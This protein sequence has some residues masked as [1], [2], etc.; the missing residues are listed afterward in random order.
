MTDEKKQLEQ[1]GRIEDL[2]SADPEAGLDMIQNTLE[3]FL[4]AADVES[5]YKEPIQHGDTLIIPAAEVVAGMGFGIGHGRGGDDEGGGGSG[6]GGGGGGRVFSR[7]VA[8]IISSPEGVRV[9]PVFDLT[10]IALAGLTAGAFMFGML[11]RLR[12][13]KEALKDLQDGSWG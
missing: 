2:G 6:T 13:P 12:N 11:A 10:K 1:V 8:V 4:A 3:T 5:V 7:P 9:D